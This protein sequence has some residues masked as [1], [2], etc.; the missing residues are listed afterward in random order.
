[1]ILASTIIAIALLVALFYWM[2]KSR[3]KEAHHLDELHIVPPGK[4]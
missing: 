4:K 3:R 1:M 2:V